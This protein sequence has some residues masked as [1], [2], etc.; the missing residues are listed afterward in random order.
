MIW[1]WVFWV[2]FIAVSFAVAEGY[3]IKTGRVTL[4]ATVW[5]ITRAW[6]LLPFV[7][8]LLAGGLA[9]HFWWI[10]MGCPGSF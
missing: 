4:S 8:G 10:G 5:K 9:V 7:A 1:F 2:L 6:P 3:A